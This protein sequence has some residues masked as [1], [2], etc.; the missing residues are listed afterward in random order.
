M[1]TRGQLTFLLISFSIAVPISAQ[2]TIEQRVQQLEKRLDDL[3]RQMSDVRQQIDQLKSGA[4]PAAAEDLTKIGT[5]ATT[6]EQTPTKET[7]PS[8]LTDV[9]TINNVPNPG[10]SKVFNPDISVIGNFLGK[11]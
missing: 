4:P 5:T 9:Q 11:A 7:P 3:S 10:A 2:Q 8:A 6:S 1:A